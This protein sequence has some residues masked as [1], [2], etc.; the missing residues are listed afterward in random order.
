ML[1]VLIEKTTRIYKTLAPPQ[2]VENWALFA[3]LK[4]TLM[5]RVWIFSCYQALASS[6]YGA[7]GPVA[8]GTSLD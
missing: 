1:E 4:A 8:A 7:F 6:I 3:A 2:S 5:A